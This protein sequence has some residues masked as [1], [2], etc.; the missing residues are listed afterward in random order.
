MNAD[1]DSVVY[2]QVLCKAFGRGRPKLVHPDEAYNDLLVRSPLSFL[3][4]WYELK[5]RDG[6]GDAAP[7]LH[8]GSLGDPIW[9]AYNVL[10][11]ADKLE[12]VTHYTC[13]TASSAHPCC[14]AWS[15]PRTAVPQMPLLD[16]QCPVLWIC[17]GLLLQGWTTLQ[18][19]SPLTF[20]DNTCFL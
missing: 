17:R 13:S 3:I 20:N 2:F 8:L 18:I 14:N 6:D 5:G 1:D 12:S 11:H 7:T 9:I 16:K 10:L 4:Q 19:K 15:A